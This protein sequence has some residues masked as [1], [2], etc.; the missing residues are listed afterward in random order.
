MKIGYWI[1]GVTGAALLHL[2]AFWLWIAVS[3]KTLPGESSAESHF[4]LTLSGAVDSLV[5]EPTPEPAPESGSRLVESGVKVGG[6]G[7]SE[8]SGAGN[9]TSSGDGEEL[10]QYRE[11]LQSWIRRFHLYPSRARRRKLEGTVLVEF[12]L[13]D[14]G[15]VV[16][17]TLV[18]SSGEKV[19][20]NAAIKTLR[21]A[22]P[23][24]APPANVSERKFP[25]PL[26]YRL[27]E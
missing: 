21:V 20:D 16:A 1:V 6:V 13:D 19:L 5:T 22:S 14:A 27:S 18:G 7:S 15:A 17:T 25:V 4:E 3:N 10:A 23:M 2:T 8:V 12:E 24:P 9:I 11:Q 26:S